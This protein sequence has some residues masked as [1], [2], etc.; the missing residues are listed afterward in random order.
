[1]E[2]TIYLQQEKHPFSILTASLRKKR[3]NFFVKKISNFSNQKSSKS[4][5]FSTLNFKTCHSVKFY[6]RKQPLAGAPFL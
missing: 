3:A 4:V 6:T 1:L 5:I 2:Q